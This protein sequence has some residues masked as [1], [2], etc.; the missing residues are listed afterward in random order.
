MV[1]VILYIWKQLKHFFSYHLL[2]V[3][4]FS[5]PAPSLLLSLLLLIQGDDTH[6]FYL[7]FFKN[8]VFSFGCSGSLLLHAGLSL[9][10]VHRLLI[11]VASLVAEYGFHGVWAS[12][13]AAFTLSCPVACGIF[14]D[15]GLN[16][17][18]LHWEG[19]FLT[20]GS[21]GKSGIEFTMVS[22][23]AEE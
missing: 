11:V 17:C 7:L 1:I 20:T 9:V 13:V 14:P 19:R 15:Q 12:V 16:P 8:Y 10:V 2:L 18:I 22:T 3:P 21:P 5:S 23:S 6:R 4:F